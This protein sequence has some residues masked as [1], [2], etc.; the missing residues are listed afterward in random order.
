M[1][2]HLRTYGANVALFALTYAISYG[3]ALALG[4]AFRTKSKGF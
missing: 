1:S 3:T 4:S 2:D